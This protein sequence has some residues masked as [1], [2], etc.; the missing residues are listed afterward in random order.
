MIKLNDFIKLIDNYKFIKK[1]ITDTA[2]YR[3]KKNL[4]VIYKIK[5]K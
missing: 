2:I 5:E 3:E 1:E 4:L